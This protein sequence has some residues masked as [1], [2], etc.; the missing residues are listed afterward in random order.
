M[1]KALSIGA[2]IFLSAT[3]FAQYK[4]GFNYKEKF[5]PQ[6]HFTPQKNWMNDPNGLVYVNGEYHLF[7]QHNPFGNRWGHMSWGHA[8][9]RDLVKWKHLPVAIPEKDSVAIF[10]GSAVIDKN[11]TSGFATKAGQQPMVAIYT[12][13]IIKDPSKPDDYRQ[14]QHMAY[15]LDNGRTFTKYEGNPIHNNGMK[16]YRDPKVFWH[17]PTRKWIML[18]VKP[19]EHII[20]FYQSSNLK[21]WNKVGE[22]GNEGDFSEIWECSDLLE[23]K[24]EGTNEKKWVLINSQQY[25]VQYFVGT[26]DGKTFKNDNDK[27]TVLRQDYGPDYYAAITYNN[28]P[29]GQAPI[30]VGWMNNWKYANDIP[31]DPWKSAMAVPREM[32]LRKID[33]KYLLFQQPVKA[34]EKQRGKQ[35][36]LSN[37]QVES[38]KPLLLNGRSYEFNIDWQP[39]NIT[40]S[41]VTV[42]SSSNKGL[43]IGYDAVKKLLYIDRSAISD[44]SFYKDFTKNSRYETPITLR[45]GTLNLR[46]LVDHSVVEVFANNGEKVMSIQAFPGEQYE[47]IN[48]FTENA[49]TTF[50]KVEFY[51][52]RSV[53]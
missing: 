35:T 4:D 17:E 40:N 51:P 7:Y 47:G 49:P 53:W 27:S 41:G 13:H 22:F 37:I 23:M 6:Y 50:R 24:V 34:L 52:L 31:T 2:L 15:S 30:M 32:Y 9:S 10:S 14:E 16:D 3:T 29:E 46:I 33:G 11:N 21:E 1:L 43:K 39:G 25:G 36:Y 28:L 48:L 20:D 19:H 42:F 8:V 12:A 38:T 26:F 44:D 45:N 5:R 18:V